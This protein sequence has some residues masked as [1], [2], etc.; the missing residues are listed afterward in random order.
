MTLIELIIVIAMLWILATMAL[1]VVK[2]EV[3][4]QE[5]TRAARATCG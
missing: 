1:P 3:K 4:R 2:F 5:G